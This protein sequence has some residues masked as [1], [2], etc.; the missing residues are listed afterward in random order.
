MF[1]ENSPSTPT[2]LTTVASTNIFPPP[3]P[4]G[5]R[6]KDHRKVSFTRVHPLEMAR[7]LTLIERELFRAIRPPEL[8]GGSFKK[9]N[10]AEI[11]PN[12][13]HMVDWFNHITA[14]VQKELVLTP[15]LKERTSML[16]QFI[17]VAAYLRDFGNLSGAMQIVSALDTASVKRLHKTWKGLPRK[18]ALLF[19]SLKDSFNSASNFA[20]YRRL[21]HET[22]TG[23]VLPYIGVVLQDLLMIE[24]LP[25]T[26]TNGMINFRKMRRFASLL[27]SEILERQ[28][29][30]PRFNFEPVPAIQEYL[31]KRTPLTEQ[32]MYRYSRLSEPSK[33][34]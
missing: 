31:A 27:R 6:F 1:D 22:S 14:W 28:A 24:E 16:A 18:D 20:N 2:S 34:V 33:M 3:K 13:V 12:V 25:T 5:K 10:K 17:Q 32:D 11:S 9:K 26:L 8:V 23:A 19:D 7:Q 15:N 21:S 4:L 29:A 30:L